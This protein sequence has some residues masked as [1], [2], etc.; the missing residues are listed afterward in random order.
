MLGV[1]DQGDVPAPLSRLPSVDEEA[2]VA[3]LPV[4]VSR[5]RPD[6]IGHLLGLWGL[7]RDEL[8][9]NGRGLASP[10]QVRARL[11]QALVGEDV[12]VLIARTDEG[13][14]G[15][16]LLRVAPAGLLLETPAL[17][18][19]QLF[20]H[21]GRRRR[22]VAHAL[23]TAVLARADR[24]G[25]DQVLASVAPGA[26]D[27]H[28]FF[29]RLGFVPVVVRRSVPTSTLRR[30]LGG[31]SGGGRVALGDL[32]SRRRT[33]RARARRVEPVEPDPAVPEPEPEAPRTVRV[34]PADSTVPPP[35]V[36]P[37]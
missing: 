32:L 30:R 28:R 19:E 11:E 18:L 5:A 36:T 31:E 27:T 16:A 7:A 4:E 8:A 25:A 15:F 26:R 17:H 34:E 1:G 9:A 2:P 10:E 13:P 14:A 12:E 20:V 35:R 37:A 21:P 24:R 3:R 6:D 22:G 23:L 29:A 33:A